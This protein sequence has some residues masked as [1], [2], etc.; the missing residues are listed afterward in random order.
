MGNY[1]KK[2]VVIQ[3]VKGDEIVAW[4][5]AIASGDEPP[6][7]E[8]WVCDASARGEIMLNTIDGSLALRTLEGSWV[9]QRPEEYL[10]LQ[11]VRSEIYPCEGSIFEETYET[12]LVNFD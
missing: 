11:G 7:M 1:R 10:V 8:Q 3:A 9:I 4:L 6:E 12:V 2:P 5:R